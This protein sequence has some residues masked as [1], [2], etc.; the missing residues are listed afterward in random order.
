[1]R[2]HSA[3]LLLDANPVENS[4]CCEKKIMRKRENENGWNEE[5]RGRD[6]DDDDRGKG[7]RMNEE[8]KRQKWIS[9]LISVTRLDDFFTVLGDKFSHKNGQNIY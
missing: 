8:I 4:F 3:R 9:S 2:P 6:E 1:M 5:K 7:K